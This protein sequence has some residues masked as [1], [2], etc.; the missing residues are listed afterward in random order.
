MKRPTVI[1]DI[2]GKKRQITKYSA[3]DLEIQRAI[4]EITCYPLADSTHQCA[5]AYVRGRSCET[6]KQVIEEACRYYK[7][8][9]KT[10]IDDFYAR[11]NR[12]RL[13]GI[14]REILGD[15]L[16]S[17]T[18]K[19]VF[20]S[21]Y[22]IAQGSPLSPAVSNVYLLEIDQVLDNIENSVYV[23]YSDDLI[24]LTNNLPHAPL[25]T[26]LAALERCH[27]RINLK[28]TSVG[29]IKEGF[30]F[31]GYHF[32]DKSVFI[33]EDKVRQIN[34]KLRQSS[35]ASQRKAI[36]NGWWA[37]CRKA[38]LLP[39]IPESVKLLLRS[40]KWTNALAMAKRISSK[41]TLRK[42]PIYLGGNHARKAT[43]MHYGNLLRA[44]GIAGSIVIVAFSIL[45]ISQ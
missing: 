4:K 37:Y 38:S 25:K 20:C 1:M 3:E 41:H 17:I 11:I 14:L 8:Y 30:E 27:L 45:S 42:P 33:S 32:D 43:Q 16:A 24:I 19:W 13:A 23:R 10:D 2:N 44:A 40:H 21:Q 31:L 5:H 9:I 7:Y 29:L 39:E 26:I 12:S 15:T 6:A 34:A 35:S 18:M 36:L 28:K 22:G